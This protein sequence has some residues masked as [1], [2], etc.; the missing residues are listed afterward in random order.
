MSIAAI[1]QRLLAVEQV[2]RNDN[3]FDLG[4]HSLLMVQVHSALLKTFPT[5][6]TIIDLFRYP[7]VKSMAEYLTQG[8]TSQFSFDKVRDRAEH[9]RLGLT[10]KR[11]FRL[12]S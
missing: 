8:G 9:R 10:R 11:Q 1:W 7:T 4:G 2:G 12:Q 5:A 3:F 6:V